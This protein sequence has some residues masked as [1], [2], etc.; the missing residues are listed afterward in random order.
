MQPPLGATGRKDRPTWP[1]LLCFQ[2]MDS[3]AESTGGSERRCNAPAST[4]A[5]FCHDGQTDIGARAP[6]DDHGGA[7]LADTRRPAQQHRLL[8]QVRCL[9]TLL[10]V[11][12]RPQPPQVDVI[13][14]PGTQQLAALSG[15]EGAIK[16][17]SPAQPGAP[18]QVPPSTP[19]RVAIP[20]CTG[21]PRRTRSPR[22]QRNSHLPRYRQDAC[23]VGCGASP[24]RAARNVWSPLACQEKGT[25]R[26]GQSLVHS[27]AR[28]SLRHQ[29]F[30]GLPRAEFTDCR[31]IAPI[32]KPYTA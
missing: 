7:G 6:A 26:L 31:G 8:R 9:G 32:P 10:V 30:L 1:F 18:S 19:I 24:L 12:R 21:T 17:H 22:L 23:R 2:C 28:N 14:G 11:G 20:G 29:M 13:P 3:S 5:R 4:G 15:P 16:A 27:T 25:K